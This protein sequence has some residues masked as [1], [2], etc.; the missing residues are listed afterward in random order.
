MLFSKMQVQTCS[1]PSCPKH[2]AACNRA[3]TTDSSDDPGRPLKRIKLEQGE[4][5]TEND[6]VNLSNP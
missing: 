3:R 2:N 5:G 4:M 1:Q 6:V